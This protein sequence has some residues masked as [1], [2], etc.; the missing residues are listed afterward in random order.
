M[1]VEVLLHTRS[2]PGDLGGSLSILRACMC[3]LV[4][5][6]AKRI[7]AKRVANVSD[8]RLS[9]HTTV[10]HHRVYVPTRPRLHLADVEVE[11]LHIRQD[12]AVVEIDA[13]LG[14]VAHA[15]VDV[16]LVC[17]SKRLKSMS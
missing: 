5:S 8:Y 15:I 1:V 10:V 14:P 2:G 17:T 11:D 13:S 6:I 3:S 7:V 9:S 16:T 4:H 12:D